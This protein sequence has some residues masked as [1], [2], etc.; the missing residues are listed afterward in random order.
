MR[1]NLKLIIM[2]KLFTITMTTYVG[3][4][5]I[6]ISIMIIK[7]QIWMNAFIRAIRYNTIGFSSLLEENTS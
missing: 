4:V 6:S 5:C 3:F 7:T 2:G 1:N